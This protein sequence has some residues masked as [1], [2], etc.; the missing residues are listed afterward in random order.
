M[1][2]W[3]RSQLKDSLISTRVFKLDQNDNGKIVGFANGKRLTLGVYKN[4]SRAIEVLGE[5][6]YSLLLMNNCSHN[7]FT[8]NRNSNSDDIPTVIVYQMPSE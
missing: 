1:D 4:M 3:I 7:R 2:L 5:I 8:A 6:Q